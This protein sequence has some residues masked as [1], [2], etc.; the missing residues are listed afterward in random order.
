MSKAR[1]DKEI[2]RDDAV[3]AICRAAFHNRR[4]HGGRPCTRRVLTPE[5]LQRLLYA[6]ISRYEDRLRRFAQL[7]A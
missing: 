3:N 7:E 2:A 1:R 6:A 4:G 5:Q